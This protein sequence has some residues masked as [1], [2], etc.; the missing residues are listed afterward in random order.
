MA[1]ERETEGVHGRGERRKVGVPA[2]YLLS[3]LD[4]GEESQEWPQQVVC[5]WAGEETWVLDSE[6]RS[7]SEEKPAHQI[8]WP[9]CFSSMLGWQVSRECLLE[10]GSG[11][12]K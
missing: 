8:S 1:F 5:Y 10:L 11:T 12:T 4:L 2:T 9:T 6:K 7:V 3:Y